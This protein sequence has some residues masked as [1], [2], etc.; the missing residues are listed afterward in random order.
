VTFSFFSLRNK[1]TTAK[2][3]GDNCWV[4]TADNR[5]EDDGEGDEG[6]EVELGEADEDGD[7]GFDIPALREEPQG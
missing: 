6:I 4:M 3:K 5:G 1:A 2:L 7:E